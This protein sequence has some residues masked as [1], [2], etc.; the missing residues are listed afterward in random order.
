MCGTSIHPNQTHLFWRT[1]MQTKVIYKNIYYIYTHINPETNEIFYLGKGKNDRAYSKSGRNSGWRE[2]TKPLLEKYEME[3]IVHFVSLNLHED[4]AYKYEKMYIS[5][6]GRI[7]LNTGTLVNR[8]SGGGRA[9]EYSKDTRK[10]MGRNMSGKNNPMY[11]RTHSDKTKKK[12][13]LKSLGRVGWNKGMTNCYSEET[14]QKMRDTRKGICYCKPKLNE[15][16]V[17]EILIL[18]KE[19]PELDGVG[20]VLKNGKILLYKRA[21]AKTYHDKYNITVVQL[22]NIITRKAWPNVKI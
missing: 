11:G 1:N 8:N 14:I 9:R 4:D 6:Y 19:R 2:Y 21:F 5:Y 16:I 20:E 22:Q 10:A 18:Y 7:D 15:E 17:K 12:I 3:D 13:G